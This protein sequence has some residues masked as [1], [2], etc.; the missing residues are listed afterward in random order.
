MA[1]LRALDLR[2]REGVEFRF[3]VPYDLDLRGVGQLLLCRLLYG[4]G[5]RLASISAVVADQRDCDIL[6]P[7]YLL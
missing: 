1:T 7:L 6:G 4:L 3:L 2:G 5:R